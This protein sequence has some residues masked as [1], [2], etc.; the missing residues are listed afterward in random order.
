MHA[1]EVREEMGVVVPKVR[2][3]FRV[4]IESQELAD[5]LDGEHFRVAE[6][7]SGSTCSETPEFSDT[8]VDETEDGH[9]EGAKIHE[10]RPPSRFGW[11]GRYRA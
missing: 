8:V 10:G 9:D 6:R 4:F 3:E 5:D 2:K 11:F 1:S 7:W